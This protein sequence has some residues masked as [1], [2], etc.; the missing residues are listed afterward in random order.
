MKAAWLTLLWRATIVVTAI[1]WSGSVAWRMPRKKP[2]AT[3]ESKLITARLGC[4]GFLRAV[5]DFALVRRETQPQP[6]ATP[7][8]FSVRIGLLPLFD[9]RN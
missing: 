2:K 8:K 1:T 6:D 9:K 5:L 3:M 4:A 7:S